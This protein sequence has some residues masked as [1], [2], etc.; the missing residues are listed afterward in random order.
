MLSIGTKPKAD[1]LG[2]IH[3]YFTADVDALSV[4]EHIELGHHTL[5]VRI[6]FSTVYHH[7]HN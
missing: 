2:W 5:L 7:I 3:K 4:Q 6:R 1:R